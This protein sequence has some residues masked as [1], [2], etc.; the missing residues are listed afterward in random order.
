MICS[1]LSAHICMYSLCEMYALATQQHRIEWDGDCSLHHDDSPLQGR[2]EASGGHRAA[3]GDLRRDLEQCS[4]PGACSKHS[5]HT[6]HIYTV[7]DIRCTRVVGVGH[8]VYGH[9]VRGGD[10]GRGHG[11]AAV[12]EHIWLFGFQ[13]TREL[14]ENSQEIRKFFLKVPSQRYIL[15][16]RGT[17]RLTLPELRPSTSSR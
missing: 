2:D 1:F 6:P 5:V 14:C 7:L 15:L 12:A 10:V 11:G 16:Y 8:V 17:S 3:L 13:C 4:P 9:N